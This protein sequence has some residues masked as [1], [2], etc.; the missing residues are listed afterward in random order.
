MTGYI[1]WGALGKIV[2][3]GLVVGAGL[4]ALFAVGV[5][6]LAGPGSTNDVGRRPRSRIALA[7]ACFAVIVGAIVTAI[8]IIGRGGH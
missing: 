3:V 6:S 7:L 1:E 8:V 4:P 5:R 2:V